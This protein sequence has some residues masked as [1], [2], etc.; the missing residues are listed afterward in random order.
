MAAKTGIAL[1]ADSADAGADLAQRMSDAEQ[2]D[3]LGLELP[4]GRRAKAGRP[5]GRLNSRTQRV[6]DYLLANYRDPLEGLVIMAGLGIDEMAAALNCSKLEAFAEKRQCAVAAMPYLHQRQALAVDFTQRR[7][8]SLSI[9]DEDATRQAA[10]NEDQF[11]AAGMILAC[12]EI[13][14]MA[15]DGGD[16]AAD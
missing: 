1:I 6:A 14:E 7:T 9:V 12:E 8:V 11:L 16:D 3:L 13:A 15:D 5:Q 10:A 4:A 2:L